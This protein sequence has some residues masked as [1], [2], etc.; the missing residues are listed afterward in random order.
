MASQLKLQ[1]L[2]AAVD[3]I[4]APL[5]SIQKAAGR[6]A[7]DVSNT[8]K[9]IKELNK[10][11][12]K[13]DGYRKVTRSLGI[14]SNELSSAQTKAQQLGRELAQTQNPTKAMVREFERA[15]GQV[16]KLKQQQEQLIITQR[17]H[18]HMLRDS[19]ID[20]RNLSSHQRD[21]TRQLGE[22]NR[23]LDQQRSRLERIN[24]Q[25]RRM[26]QARQRFDNTRL[27]QGQMAG[28]GATFAAGGAAAA[29]GAARVIAPGIAYGEQMSELQAVSR[30]TKD[31][32]RYKK[33]AS[34]SRE[35]GASTSFSATD[36]GAGQTF[37]AR[38]GF[39]P[40]AIHASMK[41]VLNM[42]LANGTDLAQTA[43]IASNIGGAFKI[44]PEVEGNMGRIADVLSGVSA[45]AN[46]DLTMLGETMKYMGSASGLNLSLE[47]AAAMAGMLGNIGIQGSQAGTTLRAMM[48]RFASPAKAGSKAMQAIGLQAADAQ[49]NMKNM[50]DLIKEVAEAT[51]GMGNVQRAALLKDIFGT[52]AGSGMAE[53]VHQQ[54][55]DGLYKLADDLKNNTKGEAAGMAATRG[56]NL[57]GDLKSL[58]SAWEEVGI[59]MSMVNDG[60]LRDLISSVTEMIRG[61]GIWINNNPELVATLSKVFA[62]IAGLAVAGGTLAMTIA[63]LL[64]PFAMLQYATSILGIRAMPAL[65]PMLK[66]VGAAFIKLGLAILT[67]PVGWILL[68]IAAIAGAAYLIYK[69]WDVVKG[70]VADFWAFIQSECSGALAIIKFLF[71]WSPLGLIINNWDTVSSWLTGFWDILKSLCVGAWEG[72]KT[73]FNWSPLG[74]IINNWDTIGDYFKTL[75]AQF[76]QFGSDIFSGLV[77]GIT[78]KLKDVKETITSAGSSVASWFKETLGIRSPS[79]V[80]TQF[81]DDTMAGLAIGLA[82]NHDPEQ[83]ITNMAKKLK[84]AGAGLTLGLAT[85]PVAAEIPDTSAAV[86]QIKGQEQA[87]QA[88]GLSQAH[89]TSSTGV[90]QDYSISIAAGAIVINAAPGMDERAIAQA[91]QRAIEN[92]QQQQAQRNRGRLTDLE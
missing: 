64:G 58:S 30:L 1:V 74:L 91:V 67:T 8:Q 77:G 21:L 3:K 63:G 43:D 86:A 82:K 28:Q 61:L 11:A 5:K 17:N 53:L 79:K 36:V 50:P 32:D 40:E 18:R 6:A 87:Q 35:L 49:G 15:Q 84:T 45:R 39:T 24:A 76:S 57:G 10:S 88:Q 48:N 9:H 66:A 42:A 7:T 90:S 29:Y 13:I 78:G 68:A 44:D 54:G 25:Q 41:D 80:F 71:D 31:D 20:T 89:T 23:A 70:W 34:Q 19:G 60:A 14:T 27:L 92:H 47:E 4:T 62:V 2:L 16:K 65:L 52:E 85:L 69:N 81:G 75:P 73:L 37:L 59:S 33:L 56:D 51:K 55:L 72:I 12:G 83:Q 22:A 46:V 38:A 26:A